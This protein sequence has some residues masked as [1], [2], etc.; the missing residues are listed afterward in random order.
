[1]GLPLS[2]EECLQLQ[3]RT[4]GWI[5]GLQLAA[6]SL[7]RH[8]DRAGFIAAFSGSHHYVVEVL[9]QRLQQ[10]VPTLVPHLRA[11]RWYKQ[12]GFFSEAVSHALAVC[13]FGEAARLIEQRL[14]TFFVLGQVTACWSLLARLSGDL[15]R[16]VTLSHRALDLLPELDTTPLTRLLRVGALQGAP[17]LPGERECDPRE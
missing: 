15:E 16:C 13:A 17:C 14:W 4:E 7:S 2:A 5:T 6:F 12:H 9:R 11:S 1:M 8:D 10:T 3:A